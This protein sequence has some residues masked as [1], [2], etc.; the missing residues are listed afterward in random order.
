VATRT[1]AGAI[2][3]VNSWTI[4]QTLTKSLSMSTLP[5][6]ATQGPEGNYE[7]FKI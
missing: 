5:P 3:H 7:T 2:C 4:D 6:R 1:A